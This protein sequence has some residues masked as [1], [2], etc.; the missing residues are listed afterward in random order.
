MFQP[1]A[2]VTVDMSDW[3][4]MQ[5]GRGA[6]RTPLYSELQAGVLR[7]L[8]QY[9]NREGRRTPYYAGAPQVTLSVKWQQELT[10]YWNNRQRRWDKGAAN[11]AHRLLHL[12]VRDWTVTLAMEVRLETGLAT[13]SLAVTDCQDLNA[14]QQDQ[15]TAQTPAP[16]TRTRRRVRKPA[17]SR[18]PEPE[19]PVPQQQ[20]T[21]GRGLNFE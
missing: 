21:R 4:P 13:I 5:L 17:E 18:R 10:E 11:P 14:P 6:H 8:R 9:G 12:H 3:K 2:I 1:H 19:P 16:R 15:N 7:A 20:T